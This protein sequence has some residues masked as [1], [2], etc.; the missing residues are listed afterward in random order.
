M[1]ASDQTSSGRGDPLHLDEDAL[2]GAGQRS[3]DHPLLV[4]SGDPREAARS[5]RIVERRAVLGHVRDAIFELHEHVGC[6]IDAE[7]VAGTEVL[8][9]PHPHALP[10]IP[11]DDPIVSSCAV[12]LVTVPT[13]DVN[14]P[15]AKQ[16]PHVWHRPTGDVDDPWAWLRD[17]DDPDTVAYLAAENR[18]ADAWFAPHAELTATLFD[19]IKSRVQETDTA[20]PVRKDQWWYTAR[21]EEGSNYPI[22]CRGTSRDHATD[23]VLLDE[24]VEAEGTDFFSLGLF[25]VT[26]DHRIAAWSADVDGSEQYTVRIRDLSTGIDLDDVLRET[27]AWGGAAWSADGTELFYLM[28]DEQMRPFQLWR[29]TI[30]TGQDADTMVF[31]EADERF[32]LGVHLCRSG[33]WIIVEAASKVSSES[34]LIPAHHP[35]AAPVPVRAR[36]ADHEYGID[37]WGDR[38]VVL[39]NLHAEDFRVMTAPLDAPG[40]WTELV[41]HNPA[42]GSPRSSRSPTTS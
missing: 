5:T 31:E 3:V 36:E 12:T 19:E 28:P 9:D 16:I 23:H 29:H 30:G 33:E 26:P 8:V 20:V 38:F 25:E 18:Y 39:T 42:S 27:S 22:H 1:H 4:A 10:T 13:P 6:V 14:P 41:A 2:T 40:T 15:T 32:Y 24:N 34:W 21:T 37:H 35:T 11:V 7:P 17:R